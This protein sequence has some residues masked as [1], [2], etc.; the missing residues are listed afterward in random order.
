MTLR[1][2]ANETDYNIL[3]MCLDHC[4]PSGHSDM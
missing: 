3:K 1:F 2:N 4:P